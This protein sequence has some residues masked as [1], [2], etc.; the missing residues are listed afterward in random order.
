MK[1]KR[2]IKLVVYKINW[3]KVNYFEPKE[4]SC[5]CCGRLVLS[6][7]LALKLDLARE[8]AGTA[9]VITS[10]YRCKAHNQDIGGSNTS[11]HLKGL[12]VDISVDNSADR[13]LIIKGLIIAGFRRIGIGSD[14]IHVDIDRSKP[15]SVWL[16]P[17][18]AK[19]K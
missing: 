14:F 8:L 7:E 2:K 9:M 3:K 5:K 10:G 6:A 13:L 15:N 18:N 17:A 4:F 16:Y 19:A 11:S 12:A 1:R